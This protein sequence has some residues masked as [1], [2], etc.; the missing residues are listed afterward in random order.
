MSGAPCGGSGLWALM[1]PGLTTLSSRLVFVRATLHEAYVASAN[2]NSRVRMV[3]GMSL[4]ISSLQ[5]GCRL[6]SSPGF[7][8][9]SGKF[10]FRGQ[11]VAG[12]QNTRGV[13]EE[14][15][16]FCRGRAGGE[17]VGRAR[18]RMGEMGMEAIGRKDRG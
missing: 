5:R 6:N 1:V 14:R 13:S 4:F 11:E 7:V 3:A 2:S 9:I 12:V 18:G 15:E 8:P 17:T 10:S 16:H